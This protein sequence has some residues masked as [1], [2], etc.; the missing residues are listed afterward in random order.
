MSKIKINSNLP[1]CIVYAPV[2]CY[3][4]YS[5]HSRDIVKSLIELKGKDWDIQVMACRWGNTPQSFIKD[6]FNEWGFMQEYIIPV[7]PLNKKPEYMVWITVPNEFQAIGNYNIGIT[8]G[9]ETTVCDP[10]WIEG[11]NRMDLTLVSSVKIIIS[12]LSS[13]NG[14]KCSNNFSNSSASSQTVIK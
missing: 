9:I 14:S 5:A 3:S 7:G 2:D 13:I 11:C 12:S 4:G 6:N 1:T 8:A 10:S